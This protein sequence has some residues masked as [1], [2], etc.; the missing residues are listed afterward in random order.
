MEILERHHPLRATI[1]L[2]A[3]TMRPFVPANLAINR[4][5]S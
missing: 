3:L 5:E 4:S 1:I 2:A